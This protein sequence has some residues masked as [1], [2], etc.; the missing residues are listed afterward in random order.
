MTQRGPTHDTV[1]KTSLR[2]D[3]QGQADAFLLQNHCRLHIDTDQI[4]KV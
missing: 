4:R 2:S 3:F 1:R